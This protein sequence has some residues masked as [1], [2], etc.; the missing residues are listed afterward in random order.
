MLIAFR[1]ETEEDQDYLLQQVLL[2]RFSI[3]QDGE[4]TLAANVIERAVDIHALRVISSAGY[5][6]CISYLWRGWLVQDDLDPSTFVPYK[7]KASTRYWD[8]VDPD[9]MRVPRYQNMVQIFFSILFLVLYTQVINSINPSGDLDV[10]EAIL[11]VFTLGFVCDELSK[12]WKIGT[13]YIGFWNVFNSTLYA[14]LTTSFIF[15]M[16]AL[17][18]SVDN[19]LEKREHYN[20]LGYNFLAFSAPMVWIRLLLYLDT[21]RFFGAMLVVVKVMMKESLIFFALLIVVLVGFLQAF[22]GM[23]EVDSDKD[24]TTFILQSMAN[25]VMQSPDFSGFQN[26]S[27]PFGIILYYIFTFVVMVGESCSCSGWDPILLLTLPS[28]VEYPHRTLQ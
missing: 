1:I 5:Q 2:R 3:I 28:L 22:L 23:D 12:V 15:R 13:Y 17:S 18:R 20:T 9:R 27:P 6:K 25:T 24:A 16:F 19:D 14:L 8:H 26:F 4:E 21:Y 11:Y 7:N 10:I